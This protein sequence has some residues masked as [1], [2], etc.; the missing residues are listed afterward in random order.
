VRLRVTDEHGRSAED[1]TRVTVDD[2]APQARIAAPSS[3]T[4]NAPLAFD[5]SGSTDSDGTIAKYEWDAGSGWQT[6]T[7][8][9]S[10]TF[11]LPGSYTVRLRVTDDSGKS[12]TTSYTFSISNQAP[13][14]RIGLPL[15]PVTGTPATFDG[16]G[17]ADA[18]GTVT[19]YQWDLNGNGTYE[20]TGA[21]PSFTYS[22]AGVYTVRLKVTDALGAVGAV[23]TAQVTVAAAGDTPPTAVLSLPST[24]LVHGS[25]VR[26]SAAGTSDPDGTV[27]R[28]DWDVDGDGTVDATTSVS[29]LDWTYALPGAYVVTLTVTDNQYAQAGASAILAIR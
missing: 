23:V 21:H 12:A 6:G 27:T 13:T 11:T 3:R 15:H 19:K 1:T 22:T 14:A 4:L 5:A 2:A 7:A 16:T 29:Y 10:P 17:S 9:F 28:Y 25:P 24:G 26:L 18:D 20:S 8:S